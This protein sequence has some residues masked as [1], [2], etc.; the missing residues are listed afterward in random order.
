MNTIFDEKGQ[1]SVIWGEGF[2]V[3][4]L[5]DRQ[6]FFVETEKGTEEISLSADGDGF[7]GEYE[8]LRFYRCYEKREDHLRLVIR[9]ENHG[10]NFAGKIGYHVGVDTYMD[11][12]PVWHEK[13]F[14]TL[15]R[16]EKTHFWGYYMNTAENALAIAADAPIAS[17][18]IVYNYSNDPLTSDAFSGLHRILGTDLLFYQNTP[19][20]ERHPTHLKVMRAGDVYQNTI[21]LIPVEKKTNIK[22]RIS[23]IA[24]LPMID[25]EKYTKEIGESLEPTVFSKGEV[26]LSVMTPE[27]KT[28]ADISQPLTEYGTYIVKAEDE[29][30]KISEAVICVRKPFAYYLERAAICALSK[31]PKASTHTETFYGLFSSFLY[32]KHTKNAAYG[33]KAYAAFDEMM[34]YMFDME[35]CEPITIPYRIQNTAGLISVMADMYEADPQNKIDYLEKASRFAEILLRAQDETGAYRNRRTHY[36]CVLYIAKSM[37]ELAAAEK[38]SGVPSLMEKAEIH[39]ASAKKAVDELVRNLDNIQTEGEMTLEDGM[40]SCSALQIGAFA[41]TLPEE[42]RAPYIRAAEYMMQIHSCLEQQLIPDARC[43]GASLRYWEA[44]YDVMFRINMLNSPHGWT[45]FTGYAKYYLYLLTGKRE[46]LVSLMNLVGSCMQLIDENGDLRWSYCSQPY[47]RGRRFVPDLTKE[48]KDGYR[49]VETNEKA[50]RGKYIIDEI[51]EGYVPMISDW[52]RVGEQ[53]VVGGYEFCPLIM[54]GYRDEKADRQGGCCDNDVH[55]VFKCMEETVLKKAYL[56]ENEDG[57]FLCYGCRAKVCDGVLQIEVSED[58]QTLI[59]NL[60]R[61]YSFDGEKLCGFGMKAI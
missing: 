27:G 41:L 26:K 49:F 11:R 60:K 2:S 20:P 17:Y 3:P 57:T 46:Y 24:S 21:Y 8:G 53:K 47:I 52:Y 28:V 25:L 30:G 38:A 61:E 12:Y 43:N 37:L 31:P 29:N 32:Y 16:C 50:Y 33:E 55:E 18:D 23:A 13:F 40:I 6:G 58:A 36:T 59:Y 56:Y 7:C 48:V 9:I 51:C 42:E 39:Y 4:F 1:I 34:P 10:G 14:P 5:A 44:Q 45:G 19:L 15:L 35:R 54:D 22:R